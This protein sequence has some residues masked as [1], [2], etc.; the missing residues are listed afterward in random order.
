LEAWFQPQ[1]DAL[2]GRIKGAEALVRWNHP[3][4]G[5]ISPAEFIPLAE[6]T[7]LVVELGQQVL[8]QACQQAVVWRQQPGW[9]TFTLAVNLSARQLSEPELVAQVETVLK[10][11][12]LPASA[13]E[14]EITESAVMDDTQEALA[15]LYQLAELG[16]RL[17]VDDFGTGYSSLAYLKS[18]PVNK[19][20]ID[21]AFV[22][23]LPDDLQDRALCQAVIAIGEAL[24]LQVLAEGVETQAQA[25][26]LASLGCQSFQGFFY[27]RPSPAAVFM[28]VAAG[29]QGHKL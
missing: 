3:D 23:D 21:R 16:V 4:E 9:E 5:L 6:E 14:L 15:V 8:K 13:L 7:G 17:S 26:L 27:G 18:L 24:D 20:K 19:I 11:S 28:E 29:Q 2:T 1:V 22:M 25:E 10:T 12:G